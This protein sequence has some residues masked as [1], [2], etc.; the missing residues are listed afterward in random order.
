MS[1]KRA[2]PESPLKWERL[3]GPG[4][5]SETNWLKVSSK[6]VTT[7]THTHNKIY[8][9]THAHKS[10]D[11]PLLPWEQPAK[12]CEWDVFKWKSI[13]TPPPLPCTNP[14]SFQTPPVRLSSPLLL[15]CLGAFGHGWSHCKDS[16]AQRFLRRLS[17][18]KWNQ[19][20]RWGVCE[21]KLINTKK[22]ATKTFREREY[23]WEEARLWF[24][25]N[26]HVPAWNGDRLI[27]ALIWI[28]KMILSYLGRGLWMDAS[29]GGKKVS[30]GPE[31]LAEDMWQNLSGKLRLKF[32]PLQLFC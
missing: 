21:Q 10:K 14:D 12:S 1:G 9:S 27:L 22:K 13:C 25:S 31:D 24:N 5:C 15:P 16:T 19:R 2:T 26:C 7:H 28:Y 8:T 30:R 11:G 17:N 3:V 6:E 20:G 23:E 29:A 32:F 18:P 4:L